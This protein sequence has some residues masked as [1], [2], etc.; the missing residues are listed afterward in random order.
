VDVDV[1]GSTEGVEEAFKWAFEAEVVDAVATEVDS[2]DAVEADSEVVDAVATEVDSEDAV[3]AEVVDVVEVD[4]EVVEVIEVV[5]VVEVDS[6]AVAEDVAEIEDAVAAEVVAE[7]AVAAEDVEE[8]EDVEE[9]EDAAVAEDVEDSTTEDGTI[10]KTRAEDSDQINTTIATMTAEI[11]ETEVVTETAETE[12]MIEEIEIGAVLETETEAEIAVEIAADP[13]AETERDATEAETETAEDETET[14]TVA[15]VTETEITTKDRREKIRDHVTMVSLTATM[16]VNSK[17]REGQATSATKAKKE[18][19]TSEKDM[20]M[21]QIGENISETRMVAHLAVVTVP[22]SA[23]VTLQIFLVGINEM[24]VDQTDVIPVDG[25]EETGLDLKERVE[26]LQGVVEGLDHALITGGD[27]VDQNRRD[28]GLIGLDLREDHL[29]HQAQKKL[30][31][32]L[33]V[34]S[35]HQI[36]LRNLLHR[37][38]PQINIPI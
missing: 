6:E 9:A 34:G 32:V 28:D 20:V 16:R 3:A 21:D 35:P 31:K 8:E 33:S 13:E 26:D 22:T 25:Q 38:L 23:L 18:A 27:E 14:V 17:C 2:E 11:T 24:M 29:H 12:A 7:D 4:S 15:A 37:L 5:D 19:T 10:T 30:R 36:R 1:V